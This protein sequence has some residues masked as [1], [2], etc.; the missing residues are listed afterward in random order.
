MQTF[1][2]TQKPEY[3]SKNVSIYVQGRPVN[4]RDSAS[5]YPI[6]AEDLKIMGI[7]KLYVPDSSCFTGKLDNPNEF[8]FKK[9]I[10]GISFFNEKETEG[11]IVP[12]QSALLLTTGDCPSII[13]H[14][15]EQNII[16]GA[17][18][19]LA[20][21]V[22]KQRLITGKKSRET[23]G[24]IHDICQKFSGLNDLDVMILC[25]ISYQNFTYSIDDPENGEVNKKLLKG[26]INEY[27]LC[28]VPKGLKHGGINIPYLIKIILY[29]N[30][31]DNLDKIVEDGIDTYTNLN[32]WSHRRFKSQNDPNAING[33]NGILI[34]HK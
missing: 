20:S 3:H 29:E 26:L 12:K 30:G 24:V 18:S 28:A 9:E 22:D 10:N 6:L 19:G 23:E 1:T 11:I 4:W 27:G 17:H 7:N 21:V 25:G 34:T 33:R 8:T 16:A 13:M 2:K 31:M 32:Y 15:S 14:D 5:S